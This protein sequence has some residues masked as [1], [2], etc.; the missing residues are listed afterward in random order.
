VEE[1]YDVERPTID[2]LR[3]ELSEK[4]LDLSNARESNLIKEARV[5][6]LTEKISELN[7]RVNELEKLNA[8]QYNESDVALIKQD[9]QRFES[10]VVSSEFT[11]NRMR[12]E[13]KELENKL[14][15]CTSEIK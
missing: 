3:K 11:I 4:A 10:I 8:S 9:C 2:L 14:T 13:A 7:K 12:E 15:D 1:K 6:E 5:T